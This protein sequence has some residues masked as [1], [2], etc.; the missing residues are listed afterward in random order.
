[1][2]KANGAEVRINAEP[3][4]DIA[5]KL[6]ASVNRLLMIYKDAPE[7]FR[8]AEAEPVRR[9]GKDLNGA[10]GMELMKKAHEMFAARNPQMARNL[11][12]VWDG[13]GNWMG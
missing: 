13:I 9:I 11:E 3:A 6:E 12:M 1:M 10:G 8:K 5:S 7:G 2:Q 4:N